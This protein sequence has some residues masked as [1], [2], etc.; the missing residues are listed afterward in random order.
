M[1]PVLR[2]FTACLLLATALS[3]CEKADEYTTSPRENFEALWKILDEHYC[4][5]EYKDVDWDEVHDRYS[6]KISDT[7]NQFAL[8]DTLGNMLAELK[9]GHTNLVSSFNLARYWK[10]YL[11]YPD[12]FNE[13]IQ[14]NYLGD[15][16]LI[17][18]GIKYTVLL[19][20]SI[21]YLYYPSFSSGVGESNLDYVFYHF[22]NC[23]GLIVDVRDN[24]GGSLTYSERIA[25]RFTDTKRLAGYMVHK[26]GPARDAF[27]D[28]FP[29]YLE[30][31]DR[32][33]WLRPVV[34]LTNRRCYSATNDFVNKMKLMPQIVTM[35][36]RTGGGSG[37][38][39][40]SEIPNGWGVRF[41]ACPILDAAGKNTEF[42]IAPDFP[43]NMTE[44]DMD[45]GKDTIIDE[46]VKYLKKKA[47]ESKRPTTA[48]TEQP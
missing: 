32:I 30:P 28:P 4:F 39:F 5:F 15:D 9:D 23:K 17:A 22:R 13:N 36:D 2:L 34:V 24:S 47:E 25:R 46:A 20:D 29:F 33:V 7:M 44:E 45:T 41:S 26:T 40:S 19:P 11:D 16:Y 43:V 37:F 42:G 38:P 10:W 1:K 31:V 18:G 6:L 48:L 8:F 12:N 14:R 21:G 27:S 3:G 35:G